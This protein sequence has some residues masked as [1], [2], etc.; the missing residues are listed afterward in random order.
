[1]GPW[2]GR[3]IFSFPPA[4]SSAAPTLYQLRVSG[5]SFLNS[6]SETWA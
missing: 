2:I 1:M 6:V 3:S 5:F 4:P